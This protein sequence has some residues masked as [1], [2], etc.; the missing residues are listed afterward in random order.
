ME[1]PP[2]YLR[3]DGAEVQPRPWKYEDESRGFAEPNGFQLFSMGEDGEP[4]TEDDV[5]SW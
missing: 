2:S 4:N 5:K 1:S 3:G